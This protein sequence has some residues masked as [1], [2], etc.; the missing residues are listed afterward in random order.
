MSRDKKD[1]YET[2]GVKKTSTEKEIKSAYRKLAKKYHPD[3]NA[4]NKQA[5]QK[6][7]EVTEAYNV[8]SDP[9]KK[10]L[11]D[12]YGFAGL[13]EGF[14]PNAYAYQNFGGFNGNFG[15]GSRSYSGYDPNS[16]TY[17][18][19]HFGSGDDSGI[20]DDLFGNMFNR[21]ES[22]FSRK[23]KGRD[24]HSDLTVSFDE[25]LSG[26][27]KTLQLRDEYGSTSSVQVKVPAGIRDG[28]TIRLKGKG[29]PGEQGGEAGDLL[30]KI[31][32]ASKKGWERKENDLYV[33]AEIPFETAVLGGE[34]II[35]TLTGNVSCKIKPGTRSGTKI[36]L[37]GKGAHDPAHPAVTGDEYAVIQIE[38]PR[39]LSR[40]KLKKLQEYASA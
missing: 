16:H 34:A 23:R 19:F 36:R 8:L 33:T 21:G 40:E 27:S 38:V 17:Q 22:G 9:E 11:Y 15:G 24:L 5:E 13:E 2:L 4:G 26:C 10:K 29:L 1:Y 30:L 20:F 3:T 39:N 35:P 31:H 7:K 6:F 18:E 25:S 37:R 28:K 12:Q 32:V 14:D